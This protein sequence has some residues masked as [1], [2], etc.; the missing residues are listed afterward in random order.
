MCHSCLPRNVP[1]PTFARTGKGT[2]L[3]D[4]VIIRQ[5]S[6]Y[7][8]TLFGDMAYNLVSFHY[9]KINKHLMDLLSRAFGEKYGAAFEIF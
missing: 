7:Q 4:D 8:I 3:L 5:W 9:G 2:W 6:E 1:D